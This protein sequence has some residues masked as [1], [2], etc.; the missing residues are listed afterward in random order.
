MS[1]FGAGTAEPRGVATVV[2][3]KAK[4]RYMSTFGA[5]TAE[6]RNGAVVVLA[7]AEPRGMN[8][9]SYNNTIEQAKHR[10]ADIQYR[11]SHQHQINSNITE[12]SVARVNRCATA[13]AGRGAKDTKMHAYCNHC[14]C[15]NNQTGSHKGGRVKFQMICNKYNISNSDVHTRL[16]LTVKC[17]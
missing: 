12:V 8:N 4:S 10:P 13:R 11:S 1:T 7:K 14:D 9:I 3:S 2:V 16:I 17:V 15:V 5:G 6:P